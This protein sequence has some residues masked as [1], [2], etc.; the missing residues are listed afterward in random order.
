MH[1]IK[2]HL[3]HFQQRAL[4]VQTTIR[5]VT[6]PTTNRK[7]IS[8]PFYPPHTNTNTSYLTPLCVCLHSQAGVSS[9]ALQ[10][11]HGDLQ[12][13]LPEEELHAALQLH[14][15]ELQP[16]TAPQVKTLLLSLQ[17]GG[18]DVISGDSLRSTCSTI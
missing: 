14:S 2:F 12:H 11:A 9:S 8:L 15:Q 7:S 18:C 16:N 3:F 1:T 17:A 5:A 13:C 10:A 6:K 4:F